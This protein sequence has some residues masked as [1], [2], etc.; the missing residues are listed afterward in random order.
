MRIFKEWICEES[1]P[2]RRKGNVKH[3]F[4]VEKII[5]KEKTKFQDVLI[6]KNPLYGKIFFLDGILQLTQKDEF[7]Y[8][9]MLSH[10]ILFS[11]P[12]PKKVLIIGGGDGGVLREVLKHNVKEVFLVE[13]DLRIVE[14]S[15]KYL[16]FVSCGSFS[17]KRVKVF[18]EK[19]EKFVKKFKDFFDIVI[20]D[21]NAPV[22]PSRALY[23]FNFFVELNKALKKEGMMMIQVGS[24]LDF[25]N[26]IKPIYLKLKKIFSSVSLFRI[27]IPSFHCGEYCFIGCSKKIELSKI[28]FKVI[29]RRFKNILKKSNFKYYSPEIQ[30]SS[31]ILPF[32]FKL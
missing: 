2:G 32:S 5:H 26:L 20:V 13:L 21:G 4:F 10:P 25:E 15:K 7:F 3:C 11:H 31:M 18:Q 27:T 30:K 1:L 8:H 9:E 17:D 22:G 6:F 24:F 23:T 16:S 14:L 28:D 12:S 19:G 29:E